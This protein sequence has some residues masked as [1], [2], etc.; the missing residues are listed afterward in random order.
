M[1][2][3]FRVLNFISRDY[4][5][6]YRAIGVYMPLKKLSKYEKCDSY[7]KMM[8]NKALKGCEDVFSL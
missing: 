8:V 5:R 2:F 4:L 1:G 7:T 3:M 6:N